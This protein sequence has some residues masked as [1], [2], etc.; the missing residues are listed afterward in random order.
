M[1]NIWLKDISDIYICMCVFTCETARNFHSIYTCVLICVA[2]GNCL[3][4]YFRFLL[5]INLKFR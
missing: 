3:E 2:T 1:H 5:T 4:K